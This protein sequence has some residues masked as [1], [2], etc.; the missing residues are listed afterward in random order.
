[1]RVVLDGKTIRSERDL[2]DRL[3]GPLDFGP[4]YGRNLGALWDRLHRDVPRP[5]ELVW[6]DAATSA[7]HLG[8][9]LYGR[10]AAL[11]VKVMESDAAYPPERRFTVRFA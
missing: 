7:E 5:V 8:E 6:E 1:M 11:L 2:H 9:E 10:I 4:Y 3:A